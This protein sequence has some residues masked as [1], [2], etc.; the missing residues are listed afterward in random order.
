M[1]TLL[2]I[3]AS[4]AVAI[5]IFFLIDRARGRA[6]AARMQQ[7][8]LHRA[9][10]AEHARAR[11]IARERVQK[12]VREQERERPLAAAR[13]RNQATA[14]STTPDRDAIMNSILSDVRARRAAR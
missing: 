5:W 9:W 1:E 8:S 3:V 13:A 11:E 7:E 12:A 2:L 14:T 4:F 6:Y 10:H